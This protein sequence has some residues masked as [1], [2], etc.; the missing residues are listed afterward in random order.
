MSKRMGA[1]AL[2]M[3][4][5]ATQ[6]QAAT[7]ALTM[8]RDGNGYAF[9]RDFVVNPTAGEKRFLSAQWLV[10]AR[11]LGPAT[12]TTRFECSYYNKTDVDG[13][14]EWRGH[15]NDFV[16]VSRFQSDFGDTPEQRKAKAAASGNSSVGSVIGGVI[17]GLFLAPLVV[18]VVAPIALVNKATESE[19]KKW[20][21]FNH[22]KF[23]EA[24]RA[25]LSQSGQPSADDLKAQATRLAE[26]V[27]T[28]EGLNAKALAA[29]QTRINNEKLALQPMLNAGVK[30]AVNNHVVTPYVLPSVISAKQGESYL[31]AQQA[32]IL[33]HYDA[34]YAVFKVS[35]A[36]SMADADA[37]YKAILAKNAKDQKDRAERYAAERAEAEQ[38]ARNDQAARARWQAKED[39]R[40]AAFRKDLKVGDSTFCGYVI[41]SKAPMYKLALNTLL[42]GYPSEVWVKASEVFPVD[43]GCANRNGR[44]SPNT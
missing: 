30:T 42:P 4:L 9:G 10:D 6:T 38:Q 33:A 18:A 41:E 7:V 22:D 12:D 31:D 32:R 37:P 15:E 39:L 1:M 11:T 5:A 29:W 34:D 20:V 36:K 26:A 35:L 14:A 17:G 21:E 19:T 28:A 3:V 13:C 2:A 43:Y 16:H 44:I 27:D 24:V 23:N 40:L 8:S 25:A